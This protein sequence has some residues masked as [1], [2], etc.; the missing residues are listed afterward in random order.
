MTKKIVIN[1]PGATPELVDMTADE[2]T[3]RASENNAEAKTLAFK[4]KMEKLA[5]DKKAGYDKLIE[6]GLTADQI[7]AL[8]GYTPPAE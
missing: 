6:L 4:N 1:G 8:T 2:E 5:T 7:T 3:Q